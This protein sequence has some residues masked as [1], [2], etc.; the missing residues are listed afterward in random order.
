MNESDEQARWHA[1]QVEL[2]L[3]SPGEAPPPPP[4]QPPMEPRREREAA[5]APTRIAQG[6][7]APESTSFGEGI[8]EF[9]D[10]PAA[11]IPPESPEGPGEQN[12][13]MGEAP[14]EVENEPAPEE[15]KRRGRRRRGRRRGRRGAGQGEDGGEPV[16]PMEGGQETPSGAG[17]PPEAD[18]GE[19]D[20]DADDSTPLAGDEE[21]EQEVDPISFAN[22][23]V[24]TWQELIASLYRPER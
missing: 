15:E 7:P 23:D 19:D 1:L 16:A 9:G 6:M 5:P 24:P 17:G 4:P 8:P 20:S 12:V 18:E 22:F 21:D 10:V 11:E 13:E 3:L 2:G 14:E